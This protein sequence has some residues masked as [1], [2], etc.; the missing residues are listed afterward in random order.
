MK[1]I[2][3]KYK[4]IKCEIKYKNYFLNAIIKGNKNN[5]LMCRMQANLNQTTID[6]ERM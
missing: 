5:K 2:I 6:S 4:G 1:D 3:N